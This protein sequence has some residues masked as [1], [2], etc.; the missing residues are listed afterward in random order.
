MSGEKKDE[1]RV[2]DKRHFDREGNVV[3]PENEPPPNKQNAR[4]ERK[5]P[6]SHAAGAPE[7]IDFISVL[8]SYIHVALISL[9][10]MEDPIQKKASENLEQARQM[11]DILDLMQHK[12]KG[13]LTEQESQYLE[14]ALYD[15]R[16]RYMK[17]SN[18]LK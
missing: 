7:K 18:L 12:T 8:F 14:S 1:I 9:G 4:E 11:I 5:T 15:L 2:E 6:D 13:N 3:Q 17:K 10:E 16:M